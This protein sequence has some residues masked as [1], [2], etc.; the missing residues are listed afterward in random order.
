MHGKIMEYTYIPGGKSKLVQGVKRGQ[1]PKNAVAGGNGS[2]I[3]RE[4]AKI[5]LKVKDEKGK[6]DVL[7][8]TKD[9]RRF[10]HTNEKCVTKS[11]VEEVCNRLLKSDVELTDDGKEIINFYSL[12]CD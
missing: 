2:W 12:L 11:R 10:F 4:P 3:V 5:L 9:L 1:R 6:F 8:V 7:D